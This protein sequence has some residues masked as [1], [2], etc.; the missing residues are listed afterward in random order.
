MQCTLM[1]LLLQ[2]AKCALHDIFFFDEN[3][4]FIEKEVAQ[5]FMYIFTRRYF[6]TNE[7]KCYLEEKERGRER[8]KRYKQINK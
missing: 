1:T 6:F 5:K 3:T 2:E 7:W 4:V 8:E